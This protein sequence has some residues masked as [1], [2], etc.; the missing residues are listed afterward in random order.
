M[1]ATIFLILVAKQERGRWAVGP[2]WGL[3]QLMCRAYCHKVVKLSATLQDYA[4]RKECTSN[5]HGVRQ[6][7]LDAG[8]AADVKGFP[9]DATT[10]QHAPAA[11]GAAPGTQPSN[12]SERVAQCYFISKQLWAKGYRLLFGLMERHRKS[13]GMIPGGTST[14]ARRGTVL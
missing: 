13:T 10:A 9:G 12:G 7:F 1:T 8:R 6:A 4:P 2:V 14:N 11:G 5:V 3:N